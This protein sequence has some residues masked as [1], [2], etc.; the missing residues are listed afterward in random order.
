MFR[1]GSDKPD[2][3]EETLTSEVSLHSFVQ[4]ST[5][6]ILFRYAF[7][8][9]RKRLEKVAL[10]RNHST[11]YLATSEGTPTKSRGVDPKLVRSRD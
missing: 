10:M 8:A 3:P 9:Q 2:R 5:T 1:C 11:V 7:V 4:S 6:A